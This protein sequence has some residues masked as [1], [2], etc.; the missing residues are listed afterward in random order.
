MPPKRKKNKNFQ[1]RSRA[2]NPVNGI[3]QRRE[4]KWNGNL[5]ESTSVGTVV[6]SIEEVYK[7]RLLA[8]GPTCMP[9]LCNHFNS[10]HY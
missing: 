9:S 2:Q 1:A 10:S 5:T 7:L 3:E 4:T 8:C 6:K